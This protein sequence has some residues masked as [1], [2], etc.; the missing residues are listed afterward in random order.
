M[1]LDEVVCT[2]RGLLW[3]LGSTAIRRFCVHARNFPGP[4]HLLHTNKCVPRSLYQVGLKMHKVV[5]CEVDVH[6]PALRGLLYS[7]FIARSILN[8]FTNDKT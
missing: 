7:T 3:T 2:Q 8:K 6:I 4:L 5:K 1:G